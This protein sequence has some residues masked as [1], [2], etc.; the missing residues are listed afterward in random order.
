MDAQIKGARTAHLEIVIKEYSEIPVK[1][2]DLIDRDDVPKV[3]TDEIDKLLERMAYL[4]SELNEDTLRRI[5]ILGNL[6]N[7]FQDQSSAVRV[8]T[9]DILNVCKAHGFKEPLIQHEEYFGA[10]L[11]WVDDGAPRPVMPHY[12]SSAVSRPSFTFPPCTNCWKN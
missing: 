10:I 5:N 9:M 6:M 4:R 3:V 2:F 7:E 8:L 12:K 1:I 11:G